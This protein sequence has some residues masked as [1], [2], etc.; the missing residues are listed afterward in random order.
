MRSATSARGT[1]GIPM[2]CVVVIVRFSCK[3]QFCM[4]IQISARIYQCLSRHLH[5]VLW[6]PACRCLQMLRRWPIIDNPVDFFAWEAPGMAEGGCLTAAKVDFFLPENSANALSFWAKDSW[7]VPDALSVG[8]TCQI[9]LWIPSLS[10]SPPWLY[11]K[12]TL[13]GRLFYNLGKCEWGIHYASTCA[14][15]LLSE[16]EPSFTLNKINQNRPSLGALYQ[17][18]F[19]HFVQNCC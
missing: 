4:Y 7:Q 6:C 12:M 9:C 1:R 16:T 15:N 13:A 10:P 17:K 11:N 8:K 18:R 2:I 5:G 3:G 19:I 14:I